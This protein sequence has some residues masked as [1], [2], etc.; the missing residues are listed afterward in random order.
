MSNPDDE[1]YDEAKDARDPAR[2]RLDLKADLVPMEVCSVPFSGYV[3]PIGDNPYEVFSTFVL[4]G[5][6]KEKYAWCYPAEN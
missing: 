3:A 2:I 6:W 5:V 4:K 1:K